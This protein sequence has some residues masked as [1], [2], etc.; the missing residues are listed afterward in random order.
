[1]ILSKRLML[2]LAPLA[3]AAAAIDARA[4]QITLAWNAPAVNCD[5]SPLTDLEGHVVYYG[6]APGEYHASVD[7]GLA[8]E[9]TITDLQAGG[10]YYFAVQAY[11]CWAYPSDLSQEV[12]ATI[13]YSPLPDLDQ[14]DMPDAWELEH[15]GSV[16]SVNGGP[17]DD[18][19]GD[20]FSNLEEYVAGTDPGDSASGPTILI[21]VKNKF[22]TLSFEALKADAGIRRYYAL[23]QTGSL[24]QPVWTPVAGYERIL[25]EDQGV[26]YTER[27]RKRCYYRLNI[28]LE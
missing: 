7:V 26:T 13:P 16:S 4:A 19:D 14:D 6:T 28:W 22:V 1:M 8:T 5:G 25:G 24:S 3:L 12:S 18:F 15:F 23:E 20:R 9:A 10:T 21:A 11:N 17:A 2:F 27:Q